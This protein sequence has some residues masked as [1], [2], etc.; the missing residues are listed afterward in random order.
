MRLA[1]AHVL[2]LV[3]YI[4][5]LYG[6]F[7]LLLGG[8]K[9]SSE[10][11]GFAFIYMMFVGPF[12]LIL[13]LVFFAVLRAR[14]LAISILLVL[15]AALGITWASGSSNTNLVIGVVWAGVTAALVHHLVYAALKP[16]MTMETVTHG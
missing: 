2:A 11:S 1:A 6:C 3:V 10:V 15:S 12:A 13:M 9:F 8:G 4:F 16:R 7:A 14:N 5:A